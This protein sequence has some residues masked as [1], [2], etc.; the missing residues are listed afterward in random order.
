MKKHMEITEITK[1]ND[2]N[3]VQSFEVSFAGKK[4]IFSHKPKYDEWI[5]VESSD[6][7]NIC[8]LIESSSKIS[9]R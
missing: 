6:G 1:D 9:M 5:T 4:F 3:S 7:K 8:M 2:D